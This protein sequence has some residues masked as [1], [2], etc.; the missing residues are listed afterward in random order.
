MACIDLCPKCFLRRLELSWNANLIGAS[1]FYIPTCQTW[2]PQ[3]QKEAFTESCG[4][5]PPL[6]MVTFA[7]ALQ[8][9][10]CIVTQ[11][12]PTTERLSA[13]HDPAAGLFGRVPV[14][15]TSV[16][17]RWT[18]KQQ[19]RARAIGCSP[20]RSPLSCRPARSNPRPVIG[21]LL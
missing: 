3:G 14:D 17:L 13:G 21:H 11:G 12:R 2:Q 16:R 19:H 6:G 7:F 9:Y 4:G 18:M 5:C 15:E 10:R 8:S 20:A 1:S